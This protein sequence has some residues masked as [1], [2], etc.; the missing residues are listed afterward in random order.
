MDYDAI[1]HFVNSGQNTEPLTPVEEQRL[2]RLYK[3][4]GDA[5]A[6]KRLVESNLRF[7]VKLAMKYRK[8]G[9]N[10]SDLIQE[11]VLGLIDAVEK[12]DIT[13]ECRL[14]TYASW[15][16]RLYMQRALEQ[17]SRQVNLPIN[18]LEILRKMRAYEQVFMTANGRLP[19]HDEISSHLDIDLYKVEQL[20]D[21]SPSFQTIHS[22]DD[23]HP[24]MERI[25]VDEDRDDARDSIWKGEAESRLH[26]ALNKLTK[27]ER[28]VLKHRYDLAGNGK[29]LSLRK[30]GQRLGL[31]AEG[32][33]R[34]EEQA[35]NKLRRPQISGRME[36]LFA[37]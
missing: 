33:R 25:L 21:H 7:V 9:M 10:V 19:Y 15:W 22:R 26:E 5:D 2:I 24:G 6:R 1:Q 30:V 11:G 27:R 29:K 4:T 28:D 31:S 35:M 18:K 36:M 37:N 32:V 3:K 17:K 34:I 23:D 8:Q 16:I 12:F 20:A 13:K 14:I